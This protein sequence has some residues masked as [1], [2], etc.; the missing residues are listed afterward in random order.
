MDLKQ[1]EYIIAIA[2]EKS[3]SHAAQRLYLSPSALSQYLNRL[4]SEEQLP[5][6]FKREKRELLL[7]D[8]GR[9]YVNGARTILNLSSHLEQKLETRQYLLRLVSSPVFEFPLI[10]EVLPRFQEEYPGILLSISYCSPSLAKEQLSEG[11]ADAAIILDH[12]SAYSSFSCWPIYEDRVILTTS[13]SLNKIS[14]NN[15]KSTPL[16]IPPDGTHWRGTCDDIS[17]QEQLTGPLFCETT[18]LNAIATLL[19][20]LPLMTFILESTYDSIS[21]AYSDRISAGINTS[22]QLSILPLSRC[23]PYF[24]SVLTSL[25]NTPSQPLGRLIDLITEHV[26]PYNHPRL[27]QLPAYRKL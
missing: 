10:T 4:E 1:L 17:A 8:A 22:D 7:T 20:R 18:D 24:V 19:S 14:G 12:Q 16:I 9:I 23:Y 13:R 3:I 21:S 15:W 2:E 27:S 25:R 6:L 11:Y 5:P 26:N